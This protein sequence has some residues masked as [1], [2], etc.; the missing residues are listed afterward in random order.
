MTPTLWLILALAVALLAGSVFLY[1]KGRHEAGQALECRT[2][3]M[4]LIEQQTKQLR[5]QDLGQSKLEKV[6]GKLILRPVDGNKIFVDGVERDIRTPAALQSKKARAGAPASYDVDRVPDRRIA[7]LA[8][9]RAN[10]NQVEV[11]AAQHALI[12]MGRG[13]RRPNPHAMGS[14]AFV[15]YQIA[16]ARAW[17]DREHQII[18]GEV[19]HA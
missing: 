2:A 12:D 11:T 10:I 19:S 4:S 15:P 8:A 18:D 9:F 1:F 14:T 17:M 6:G 7:D 3:D 16:Y 5:T 13:V